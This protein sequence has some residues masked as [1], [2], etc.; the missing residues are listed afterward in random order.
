MEPLRPYQRRAIDFSLDRMFAKGEQGS[1]LLLQP[2]LG[3]TRSTLEILRVLRDLGEIEK[4]LIIAPLRVCHFPWPDENEKWGYNFDYRILCGKVRSQLKKPSPFIDLLNPEST[5]ALLDFPV[6]YDMV[7]VDESYKFKTWSSKRMKA[8]KT[9]LPEINKRLILS[10]APAANSL[11][12]LHSQIYILDNGEALGRNVTIFRSRY[13]YREAVGGFSRWK[14]REGKEE[15][16]S[17]LISPLV[18]QMN[19]EDELDMPELITNTVMCDLP[20]KCRA[21]Y[22]KLKRDLLVQLES[23]NILAVNAASAYIKMRQFANGAVYD[24]NKKVHFVHDEKIDALKDLVESLSGSPLLVFYQFDHDRARLQAAFHGTPAI[25]G[26][27]DMSLVNDI[28]KD[29]NAG[30]LP[31][32]FVQNQTASHGLNM[33]DGGCTNVAYFGLTDQPEVFDQSFRRVYRQGV[34]G[35]RVVIHKILVEKTVD[36]VISDRLKSKDQTQAD[37]FKRLKQHAMELL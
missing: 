36:E 15:E 22:N 35:S 25:A 27:I 20:D 3:K 1:G 11:A 8:M 23:A 6:R 13:M 9:I 37:F 16:I 5:H 28:L 19:A 30:K 4:V 7:V 17:R 12:D 33:Q 31:L 10:G 29:W 32:L 34:K 18:I 26:N 21:G 24:E 14:M 2:G